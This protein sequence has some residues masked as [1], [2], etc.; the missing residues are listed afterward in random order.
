MAT[1]ETSVEIIN[2]PLFPLRGV[3]FFP[4]TLLPLHIFE[5]RYRLMVQEC[6]E[7]DK[8]IGMVLTKDLQF[9]QEGWHSVG[10][11]GRIAEIRR[12]EQGK[13]DI[14]LSGLSRFRI[15]EIE[16]EAPYRIARVQLIA[17][18]LPEASLQ[19]ELAARLI[20]VFKTLTRDAPKAFDPAVLE[21]FDFP[22][23]VNSICA[24]IQIDDLAKQ[25][26]LEIDALEVR[27]NEILLILQRLESQRRLVSQFEYLRPDDPS[28]N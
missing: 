12:L 7:G 13:F 22:T 9:G 20:G 11:M 3:V 23:L 6:M 25:E 15:I 28:F 4:H 2:I 27:A 21:K 17:E 16:R 24:T 1:S 19:D 5:P 26:L 18:T 8:Q 14:L 10:G